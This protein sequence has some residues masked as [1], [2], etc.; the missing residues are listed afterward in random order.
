[1]IS[2]PA[3]LKRSG[4]TRIFPVQRG[5]FRDALA[6]PVSDAG[7]DIAQ[8]YPWHRCDCGRLDIA[9]L[10][11]CANLQNA[12]HGAEDKPRTVAALVEE[13]LLAIARDPNPHRPNRSEPRAVKRRR[14]N[15]LCIFN[16]NSEKSDTYFNSFQVLK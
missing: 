9:G 5:E 7:Q 1:L 6:G 13:M 11:R 2:I 3:I 4:Q 10:I 14:K 8:I 15:Y 12:A 16:H